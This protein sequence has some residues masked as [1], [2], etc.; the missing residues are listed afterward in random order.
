MAA[1]PGGIAAAYLKRGPGAEP[2]RGWVWWGSPQAGA[3]ALPQEEG[4]VGASPAQSPQRRTSGTYSVYA[5][6]GSATL[7]LAAGA[8]PAPPAGSSRST[9]RAVAP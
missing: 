4:V 7:R 3:P 1:G 2:R 9:T 8:A 5:S 6:A